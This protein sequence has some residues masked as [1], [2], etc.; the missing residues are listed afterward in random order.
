LDN[1]FAVAHFPTTPTTNFCLRQKENQNQTTRTM[2]NCRNWHGFVCDKKERR[3]RRA[4]STRAET[5]EHQNKIAT[6]TASSPQ[7][8]RTTAASIQRHRHGHSHSHQPLHP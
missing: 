5:S 6:G 2:L 4:Q 3:R 1:C 8:P 7:A